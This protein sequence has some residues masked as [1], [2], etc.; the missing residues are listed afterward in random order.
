MAR[1]QPAQSETAGFRV[2]RRFRPVCDTASSLLLKHNDLITSDHTGRSMTIVIVIAVVAT[3]A[4]P[5]AGSNF[6]V[7][8]SRS[9]RTP[10]RIRGNIVAAVPPVAVPIAMIHQ[11]VVLTPAEPDASPTPRREGGVDRYHRAEAN[12]AARVEP[13]ARAHKHNSGIVVRHVVISGRNGHN[14]DVSRAIHDDPSV[15]A[16]AK[17]A[18]IV[19]VLPHAL[20]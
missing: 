11:N 5:F 19:G 18:I 14:L 6:V 16:I 12:R 7:L 9:F 3:V 2:Q 4:A 13:R 10:V 8:H 17:V 20:D 15:L 1:L